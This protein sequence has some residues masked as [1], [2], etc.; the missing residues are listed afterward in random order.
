MAIM[1]KHLTPLRKGGQMAVHKGKGSEQAPLPARSEINKL[2]TP[3]TNTMNDYA[4]ATPMAAPVQP[5]GGFPGA[6]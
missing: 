4:K 1:K 5:P 3:P 6:E 2:A